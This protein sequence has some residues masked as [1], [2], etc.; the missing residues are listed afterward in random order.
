MLG[1]ERASARSARG[2]T[3]RPGFDLLAV[4]FG[5]SARSTCLEL[6]SIVSSG[7]FSAF[8]ISQDA[9]STSCLASSVEGSNPVLS[10]ALEPAIAMAG[11]STATPICICVTAS[12]PVQTGWDAAPCPPIPGRGCLC[13][14]AS[15]PAPSLLAA[16]LRAMSSSPV[17]TSASRIFRSVAL[18][19]CVSTISHSASSNS[20]SATTRASGLEEGSP[21]DDAADATIWRLSFPGESLL[22]QLRPSARHSRSSSLFH[23]DAACGSFSSADLD[24]EAPVVVAVATSSSPR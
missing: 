19:R 14:P 7:I 2:C 24:A 4:A 13:L 9:S 16:D 10:L 1:A 15:L 3:A 12:I 22:E 6:P 21:V 17:S 8:S 18:S 23:R 11:P 5:T 20:S